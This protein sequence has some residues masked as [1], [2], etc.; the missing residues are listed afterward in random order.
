M[1]LTAPGRVQE[2]LLPASQPAQRP[3]PSN[4][5][6]LRS[7]DVVRGFTIALMIFVDETG[8]A[9]PHINHAPWNGL[10]LA[11][12][13][14]PWFLFMAGTSLS[15]S[16]RKYQRSAAARK[17]AG[18]STEQC[19]AGAELLLVVGAAADAPAL[20]FML[21]S[22]ARAGVSRKVLVVATDAA[23]AAALRESGAVGDATVVE[24]PA[25]GGGGALA[26]A[27]ARYAALLGVLAG[28][29][30]FFHDP[31]KDR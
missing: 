3:S 12:F 18:C 15:F 30:Q 11:D 27:H 24:R 5:P 17:A 20:T 29:D 26:L 9:Y 1:F 7:L 25:E 19:G 4:H 10:T 13:V 16:L 6:R 21:K 2:A 23:L 31:I 14:M 22:A 28:N 8:G